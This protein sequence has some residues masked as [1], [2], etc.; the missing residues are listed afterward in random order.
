M[1]PNKCKR[2][3]GEDEKL[4]NTLQEDDRPYWICA[5]CIYDLMQE[6][7]GDKQ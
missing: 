2:C 4:Y 5:G 7:N 1:H 3:G 6:E